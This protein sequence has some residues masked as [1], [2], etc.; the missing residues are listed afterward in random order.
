MQEP[1]GSSDKLISVLDNPDV[2]MGEIKKIAKEIKLD[3]EL[4]MSL[5]CSGGYRARLL[6]V[7]ILDKRTLDEGVIARMVEDLQSNDNDERNRVTEW[8]M[9]NQLLRE[10]RLTTLVLSWQRH[11]SPDLR[12][13]FWYHQ[14]RLRWTG[15]TPPEN[16]ADLVDAIDASL[17]N[18]S[19][20]VQWAMNF[21]AGWI[22]VFD[23]R[24]R[25]RLMEIG[26]RD[27][28]YKGDPVPRNCT[29]DYLPEFIRI[30]VAK[31]EQ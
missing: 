30:E 16:T 25:A 27:G 3:H 10:K 15:Q 14:A 8:L 31:R 26:E 2:K 6:A 17:M 9:T 21:A 23:I 19:P 7:L 28:L 4:A 20:E 5:W 12:R 29:P 1:N 13:M 18:E 24:F 11:E 22:G